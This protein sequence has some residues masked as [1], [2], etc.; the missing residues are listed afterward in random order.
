MVGVGVF[1]KVQGHVF[2]AFM[3]NPVDVHAIAWTHHPD[4]DCGKGKLKDTDGE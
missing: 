3:D 4:C 1:N 2:I